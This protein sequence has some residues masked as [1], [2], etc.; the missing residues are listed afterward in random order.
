MR[1]Y[2]LTVKDG[3]GML[4]EQAAKS[5]EVWRAIEDQGLLNTQGILEML[6]NR[7]EPQR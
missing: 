2:G 5:F 7:L 1:S 4:V 3:L 6:R